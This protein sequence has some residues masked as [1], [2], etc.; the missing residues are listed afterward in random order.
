MSAPADNILVHP[1]VR[2]ML[3]NIKATNEGMRGLLTWVGINL[4]LSLNHP[5][6]KVR[7]H[8]DDLVALLTPVVKS[9]C[10]ERG[11]MN[12]SEA[13]QVCGGA[14]YT[15]DWSIEQ[16][17]RDERIAMLY[18]GTNH[19]QALDLVGRK[20]PR[21]GGRMMQAFIKEL[22]T[23]IGESKDDEAMAEFVG[24]LG[25]ALEQLTSVTMEMGAK[26]MADAEEAGAAASNYLN[27]FGHTAVAYSWCVQVKH[28]LAKGGP[29]AA[30]KVK[31]ARYFFKMI[32]PESDALA[33]I[34]R[35]GKQ[36][37]M[38]FDADEL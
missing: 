18:E 12:V 9:Y 19:I 37:I 27:M 14:G 31:T 36:H 28:A 10:T 24:P 17:L 2:R 15:V 35:E 22:Q 16:Y 32:L 38:A 6:D 26:A 21:H 3:L 4:D 13:M 34:I 33:R 29:L 7:E 5:D 23:I 20:L 11:F 8:A 25:T 30:S 1:D